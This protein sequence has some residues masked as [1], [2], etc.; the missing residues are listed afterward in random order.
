MPK[1]TPKPQPVLIVTGKMSQKQAGQ[2]G[3]KLANAA[4]ITAI[5]RAC[6]AFTTLL[7][8]LYWWFG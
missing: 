2:V 3:L 5:S 4:L 6:V 1:H 8:V 7:A